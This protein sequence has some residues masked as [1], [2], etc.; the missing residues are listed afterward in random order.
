MSCVSSQLCCA[1]HHT[2][3]LLQRHSEC[4][5]KLCED[6]CVLHILNQVYQ[7]SSCLH[8]IHICAKTVQWLEK[9]G[10]NNINCA[11]NF[12]AKYQLLQ[13]PSVAWLRSHKLSLFCL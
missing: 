9:K 13:E 11:T 10:S 5:T 1:S 12:Q 3:V 4:Q 6:T 8:T 7:Q 2:V